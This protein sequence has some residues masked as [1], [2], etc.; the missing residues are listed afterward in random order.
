MNIKN[1]CSLHVNSV[2]CYS[3]IRSSLISF[4]KLEIR[5]CM[6]KRSFSFK[7]SAHRD[8]IAFNF[9]LIFFSLSFCVTNFRALLYFFKMTTLNTQQNSRA[10]IFVSFESSK[11]V[12]LD[13]CVRRVARLAVYW[14]VAT[15]GVATRTTHIL[16]LAMWRLTYCGI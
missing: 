12:R 5:N 3:L 9:R 4:N 15:P 7:N 8:N 2:I 10:R 11:V 6:H 13:G 16:R 14:R 1:V